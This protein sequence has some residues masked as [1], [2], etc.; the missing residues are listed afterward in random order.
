MQRRDQPLSHL[1]SKHVQGTIKWVKAPD[2]ATNG[3]V[4]SESNVRF[5]ENSNKL[6]KQQVM[7][8]LKLGMLAVGFT[9]DE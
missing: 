4:Y 7:N 9:D 5:Y 3:N 8:F 1:D 6:T 2:L